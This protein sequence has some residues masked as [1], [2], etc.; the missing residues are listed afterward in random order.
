[1]VE[2]SE[3]VRKDDANIFLR[4]A[5]EDADAFNKSNVWILVDARRACDLQYFVTDDRFIDSKIVTI[6]I[7]ASDEVRSQRGYVFTPGIDDV[8]SECGLDSWTDWTYKIE[9]N[10]SEQLMAQL[11]PIIDLA[12]NITTWRGLVYST[13]T[14]KWQRLLLTIVWREI[15]CICAIALVAHSFTVFSGL[16]F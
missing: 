14:V 15:Y 11:V 4:Q 12:N 2:W 6:R 16:L 8:E 1:M 10:D 7:S 3:S 13:L 5:I 9:N